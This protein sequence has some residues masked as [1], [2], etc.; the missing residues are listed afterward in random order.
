MITLDSN[1]LPGLL[2]EKTAVRPE[3][4][5]LEYGGQV[6]SYGELQEKTLCL[7][8]GLGDRDIS[9]GDRVALWLPNVPAYV[10]FCFALA[11][12]GAVAVAVN[13]RFRSLEVEDIVG[14]SGAKML[15]FWPEFKGIDFGGILKGLNPVALSS[16][17]TVVV[18]GERQEGDKESEEVLGLTG[19]TYAELQAHRPKAICQ[20]TP[21]SPC[22][23]FT[24][25]G[26]TQTPKFV[27]HKQEALARHARDVARGFGFDQPGCLTLQALPLCGVFGWG[28]TL[29]ALAGGGKILVRPL[30]DPAEA[31]RDI[32]TQGV[33]HVM[34]TDDMFYR[35]LQSRAEVQPFPSLKI[36]GFAAFSPNLNTF[37]REAETRRLPVVGLY[38]MIEVMSLFSVQRR[39]DPME[40]RG[41]AGGYPVS[42]EA[43]VRVR[44]PEGG[45]VLPPGHSG[46]IEIKGPS[47]M[48]R[49]DGNPQATAEAFT[50]DG[51]LRTGDAGYLREDGSF[52]FETRMGDVLRLAGF[53]VSPTEIEAYLERHPQVAGAQ[54]VGVVTP[55][56]PKAF[57][58]VLLKEGAV[59]DEAALQSYCRE[60]MA[61]YKVPVRF[62]AVEAF[63]VTLSANATKVQRAAL[64][65]RAQQIVDQVAAV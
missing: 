50:E 37:L 49:Y 11:R 63:P 51:F 19:V 56:G 28:Q 48:V 47:L 29:G 31:A 61:N 30:F 32:I 44:D 53:L 52:V 58:F 4:P 54:V 45:E 36:C 9:P 35:M 3:A 34:S 59:L 14:R 20:A 33:T 25:S 40:K 43:Q 57:A 1:T 62:V 17:K 6:I 5:A 24:T 46:E 27:L 7:A 65:D 39:G 12:L 42:Q 38:G 64:R 15:V 16:L 21:E 2:A 22:N 55:K 18:Y 41:A 23:I 8:A 10:I 60:G 26:T 13:T